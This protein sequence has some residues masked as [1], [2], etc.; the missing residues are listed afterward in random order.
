[1]RASADFYEPDT[2]AV[3][4][5]KCQ[6]SMTLEKKGPTRTPTHTLVF[7]VRWT[8]DDKKCGHQVV[9]IVPARKKAT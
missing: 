1:M 5:P 8:C 9:R 3:P 4:C 6:S 2:P 7:Q